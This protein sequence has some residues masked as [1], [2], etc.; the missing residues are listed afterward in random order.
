M[1]ATIKIC[2]VGQFT[3]RQRQVLKRVTN[4][5]EEHNLSVRLQINMKKI[6][7]VRDQNDVA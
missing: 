4:V 5:L 2:K 1:K 3:E 7:V 6:R